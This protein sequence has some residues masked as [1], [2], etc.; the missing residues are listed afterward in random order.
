MQLL[1]DSPAA[2]VHRLTLNRPERHNALS[3]ALVEVLV[4]E[5]RKCDGD[6]SVRVVI[7]RGAGPSFCAGAD[8]NEHFV[9]GDEP[10]DIGASELWGLLG[11]MRVPVIASVHGAAVTGGFL[12][13]YSCDLIVAA[14]SARFRDTHASLGLLPTGG[15][16][17]RLPRRISPFLARELMFTSRP[18]TGAEAAAAGLVNRLVPDAEL[19]SVTLELA[20]AVASTSPRSVAAL[21]Q[22]INR[23]LEGDLA[24][25]FALERQ[26]NDGG[27]ANRIP[28][29][30][31]EER[32]ARR[33]G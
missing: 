10:D 20:D 16:S 15:E 28:D 24:S 12:L 32:L 14:T 7:I 6:P 31:R 18:F 9:G 17:Q 21:K 26:M 8:L 29:A 5:L 25:G 30:E 27:R 22:L 2:H 13:A 23:G 19:E 4:A 33:R 3:R 11:S 1:T